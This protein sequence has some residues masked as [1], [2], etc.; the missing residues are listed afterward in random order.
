MAQQVKVFVT[1]PQNSLGGRNNYH[2]LASGGSRV[3][4]DIVIAVYKLK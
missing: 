3:S 2:R 1:K 4:R